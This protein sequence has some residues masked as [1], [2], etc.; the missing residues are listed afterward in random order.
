MKNCKPLFP[1]SVQGQLSL[2]L[3]SSSNIFSI[4]MF[5]FTV[6]FG[7]ARYTY[8]VSVSRYHVTM[9]TE[10]RIYMYAGGRG[11]GDPITV[12]TEVGQNVLHS[13]SL[14]HITNKCNCI[15]EDKHAQFYSYIIWPGTISWLCS[16]L[17]SILIQPYILSFS[18]HI[19]YCTLAVQVWTN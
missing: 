19:L 6:I 14:C 18:Q 16:K 13:A 4:Q 17:W 1:N 12:L 3:W 11:R 7:Q 10:C 2:F 15:R 8:A 5:I 9:L